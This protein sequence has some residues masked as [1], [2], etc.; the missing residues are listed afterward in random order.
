MQAVSNV[1]IDG[2][3]DSERAKF[4]RVQAV[5]ISP[6]EVSEDAAGAPRSSSRIKIDV[7]E[8]SELIGRNVKHIRVS[9]LR[10]LLVSGKSLRRALEKVDAPA[11]QNDRAV[12]CAGIGC[13]VA[14][15]ARITPPCRGETAAPGETRDV[16]GHGPGI[17]P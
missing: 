11:A 12:V 3:L 7:I 2:A 8:E 14:V 10:I 4:G 6:V 5:N 9:R 17:A 15:R 1:Q 16:G 13:G